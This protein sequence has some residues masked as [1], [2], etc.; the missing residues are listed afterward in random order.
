MLATEAVSS[1]LWTSAFTVE[2][3]RRVC[4]TRERRL[5]PEGEEED[6]GFLCVGTCTAVDI[7]VLRPK[8]ED[9]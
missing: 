5:R 1:L 2:G 4:E 6:N 7:A 8:N 9:L 3:K